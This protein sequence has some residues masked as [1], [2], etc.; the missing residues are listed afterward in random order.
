[1]KVIRNRNIQG[2][3]AIISLAL[4]S[5]LCLTASRTMAQ[6]EPNSFS[7]EVPE[8]TIT[9]A[10]VNPYTKASGSMTIVLTGVFHATRQNEATGLKISR[11]TGGQRGTFTFVPDDP[12]QPTITGSFRFSLAGKPQ[13]H[14]ETI[15]FAF[16]MDGLATDGSKVSFVQLE[17]A[18][19]SE[20]SP[21][22]SFGSTDRVAPANDN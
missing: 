10:T 6:D 14:T 7:Q 3:L 15:N 20:G 5:L 18:V 4:L 19:V 11:V 1:M 22:I 8:K 16:R 13:P 17:R 21:D 12:S 2:S 9:F